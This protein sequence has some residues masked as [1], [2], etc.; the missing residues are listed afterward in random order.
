[1]KEMELR[2]E[3]TA[4]SLHSLFHNYSDLYNK[5]GNFFHKYTYEHKQILSTQCHHKTIC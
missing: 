3:Y 4:N 5:V 2:L 1:M